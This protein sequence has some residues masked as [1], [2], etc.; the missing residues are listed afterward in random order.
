MSDDE[1]DDGVGLDGSEG[2]L[3]Q[4][5]LQKRGHRVKVSRGVLAVVH[6]RA[7]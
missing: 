5:Y 1:I 6:W 2:V 4:D 7:L 3:I